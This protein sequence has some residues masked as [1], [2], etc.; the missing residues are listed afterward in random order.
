MGLGPYENKTLAVEP[1]NENPISF[2]TGYDA[3]KDYLTFAGELPLLT[4][5]QEI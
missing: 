2:S 3:V 1:A 4:A 5:E